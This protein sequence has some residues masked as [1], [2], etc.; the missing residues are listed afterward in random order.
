MYIR[1]HPCNCHYCATTRSSC[2]DVLVYCTFFCRWRR[3]DG[4]IGRSDRSNLSLPAGAC[5]PIKLFRPL[6]AANTS[7]CAQAR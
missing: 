6:L 7:T 2:W 4:L 5:W 3:G 1:E